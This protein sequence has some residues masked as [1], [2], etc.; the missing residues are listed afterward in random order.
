MKCTPW[1]P[2]SVLPV[3]VGVYECEWK[4]GGHTL[5]GIWYNYWDGAQFLRGN[6]YAEEASCI[7][8]RQA[9]PLNLLKRWRGV[10]L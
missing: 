4:A 10:H 6:A 7:R 3:H 9:L 5:D 2:A 8:G 1:Y